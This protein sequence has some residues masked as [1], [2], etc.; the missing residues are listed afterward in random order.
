[1]D[2]LKWG[3]TAEKAFTLFLPEY[4][5]AIGIGWVWSVGVVVRFLIT[6]IFFFRKQTHKHLSLVFSPYTVMLKGRLDSQPKRSYTTTVIYIHL[7]FNSKTKKKQIEWISFLQCLFPPSHNDL[8]QT[9]K[10]TEV[11]IGIKQQGGVLMTFHSNS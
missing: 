7:H 5:T 4:Y 9:R 1:M 6:N 10:R 2:S 11:Q 8:D 3:G